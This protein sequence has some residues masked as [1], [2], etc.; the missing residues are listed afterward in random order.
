MTGASGF[1]GSA[2]VSRLLAAGRRV[3]CVDVRQTP[4]PELAGVEFVAADVLDR[5]GLDEAFAGADVVYHLAAVISVAGDPDGRVWSTNVDG[6]RNVAAAALAADVGRLVHCSSIHAYDI[7]ATDLVQEGSVPATRSRLPVYDRSKAA[8][9]AAVRSAIEAGLDAVIVNPT[10]VIGPDDQAGS[11]MNQVLTRMFFRGLPVVVK[12][13]FDWVD[14]RDVTASMVAAEAK[15]RRGDNYLL[16]GHFLTLRE[17]CTLVEEV[18]GTRQAPIPVPMWLARLGG[19]V[20]TMASRRSGNPMWA[21][22][23]ALHAVRYGP[24]VAGVKAAEELG[25]DPRPIRETVRDIYRWAVDSGRLT[26]GDG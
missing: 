11:R 10:A 20:A 12:G 24:N 1:L 5:A 7:E 6:V 15:G 25:H 26:P 22:S 23:E 3:R 2:L 13:G 18:T 8:G 19:P 4:G 14:V 16:S 17:L 21:T 9:E